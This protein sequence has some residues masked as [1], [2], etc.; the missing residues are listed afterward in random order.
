MFAAR[1]NR[2]GSV[3]LLLGGNTGRGLELV[4]F[5]LAGVDLAQDEPVSLH[6]GTVGA[7][8]HEL[9]IAEFPAESRVGFCSVEY[10]EAIVFQMRLVEGALS[11]NPQHD[12]VCCARTVNANH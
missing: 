12:I 8:A 1:Q 11:Q 6:P 10:V 4:V 2:V 3:L 9:H 7:D 5:G